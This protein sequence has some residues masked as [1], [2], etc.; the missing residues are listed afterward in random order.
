MY[1]YCT[2]YLVIDVFSLVLIW[3]FRLDILLPLHPRNGISGYIGYIVDNRASVFGTVLFFVFSLL[4]GV[5]PNCK[6]TIYDRNNNLHN[7]KNQKIQ[8][9][10]HTLKSYS[11]IRK[12]QLQV[13]KS[14]NISR[15][16]LCSIFDI[17]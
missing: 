4:R 16:E 1:T 2:F 11:L 5:V 8:H 7:K 14:P 13:A 3:L 10:K 17:P 15:S 6:A 9:L 12:R